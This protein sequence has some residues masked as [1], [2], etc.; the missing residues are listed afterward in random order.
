MVNGK[1]RRG[2]LTLE[3]HCVFTKANDYIFRLP[4]L[5]GRGI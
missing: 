3:L 4:A 5:Q 2:R 1:G